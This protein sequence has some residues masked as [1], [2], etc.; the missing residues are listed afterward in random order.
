ML[1]DYP[2]LSV[3]PPL[4]A[5]LIALRLRKVFVA[6]FLS[7]WIGAT[8]LANGNP[9]KGFFGTVDPCLDVFKDG[10]MI[11]VVFF[12]CFIGAVMAF[13]QRSGGIQGFIDLV[14]KRKIGKSRREA[15]FLTVAMS[16]LIPI[17][18]SINILVP[19]TISRPLYDELRISRQK[20]AFLC[21]SFCA[22]ICTLIPVNAWGAYVSGIMGSQ[23]VP[24]PFQTYIKAIPLNLYSIFTIV[25]ALL[26]IITQ[27]DFWAMARAEKRAREGSAR[28]QNQASSLLDN[29]AFALGPKPGV[30]PRASN[31]LVPMAV[32]IVVMV[33]G[34]LITGHGRFADGEGS[35]SVF[36][37]VLAAIAVG[38]AKYRLSK[39]MRFD[40]I[41]GLFFKSV[42]GM[43]GMAFLLTFSFAL[44][45]LC[46]DMKTGPFVASATNHILDP[47]FVPVILFALTSFIAFATG[48]SWGTWAIMFPIGLG[49]AQAAPGAMS[50][51]IGALISGGVFA[52]HCSPFASE[53]IMSSL[54]TENDH[55]DNMKT[56]LPYSLMIAAVTAAVF[57]AIGVILF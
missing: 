45:R 33:I 32:L 34:M 7:L 46:L 43:A 1:A 37:A 28:S 39:I 57:L 6:L 29:E 8:L 4:V 40:E 54:A 23:G 16:T 26:L 42:G 27:R 31:M 15:E 56:I 25:F 36:F 19:G 22:P 14:S 49:Y 18:S 9:I 2:W 24:H 48:T 20:L 44:S 10:D 47:K 38:G 13:A 52:N 55:I 21:L 5:V 3:I 17:E 11:Q 41:L 51:I 50:V 53:P 30:I 35:T 12:C